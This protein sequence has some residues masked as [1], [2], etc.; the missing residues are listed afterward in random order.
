MRVL[1][2]EDE[3]A[4]YENLIGILSEVAPD[5]EITGNTESVTQTVCWLQSNLLP[6]LIFMDIH[7]S[8]GSAFT[9]F[10]K[11]KLE[12]PVV[13]TTAYDR[14][15][16]EAF[17]VNSI[18]Y[19]LKPVKVG[20]V[21][22][23]LE[24][25][26]KLTHLDVIQYLSRLA[27]LA[28]ARKYKDK[29]LVPYKDRLLPV[30]LDEVS[31]FYTSDKSTYIYLRDGSKYPYSK[32]LEQIMPILSPATFIRAN[33]QYILNRDSVTNIT[34]WFDS[35]LLVTLDVEAPERIYISKNKASEFKSWMVNNV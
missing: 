16:I 34:I 4:A 14:Y 11:I 20:D 15:A 3:T 17:K 31:F 35:R 19:L 21:K 30:N 27:Q 32:T 28:P 8:D 18:D 22:H 12:V 2:V 33:K 1:I 26:S 25:Y 6:D 9:I 24:K 13:F 5:I 23:A 29:L 7:L 10:D